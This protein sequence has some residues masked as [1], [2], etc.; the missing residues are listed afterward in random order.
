MNSTR[1]Q[2]VDLSDPTLE[3]AGWD[4]LVKPDLARPEDISIYELHVRDFS[5]SDE[6]VP[7][8]DRGTFAAFTDEGSD[9]MEHL[10]ELADA[11]LSHVHLLPV[12]DIATIEEDASLR[13]EPDP[14]VLA[15][16]P[17][18]SDEQ[19]SAVSATADL[20]GF[21]WG[22]DPLHYTTPEGSYSTDPNGPTRI[23]EFRE[24]VQSLSD[25]GLRVVMDVVYNHT[26]ASR[27]GGHVGA[28]PDRARLLPPPRR[29]GNRGHLHVL[30]QHGDRE[31]DD[32]Q[33]DDRLGRH[34][35]QAVQGRRLPLRPD[36]PPHEAEHARRARR[37]RRADTRRRRRGRF[38]DLPVRRRLEL[39]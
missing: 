37:A 16:F 4:G 6:T 19:Q 12:F 27:P 32:G 7:A 25:T 5:I 18:D 31:R 8:V 3:P 13:Q 23:V 39:R 10:A 22:Y 21:N 34:V 9:G 20:D 35:G 33:A 26:N 36:G 17:P 15:G 29:D 28:R 14:A 38:V 30:F 2:I 1:S 24:M 11:G